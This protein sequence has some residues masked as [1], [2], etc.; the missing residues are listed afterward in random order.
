MGE[1]FLVN[2]CLFYLIFFIIILKIRKIIK[3]KYGKKNFQ[4]KI[5]L[6][7]DNKKKSTLFFLLI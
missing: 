2:N 6:S 7:Y 1:N 4:K 5:K 3:K